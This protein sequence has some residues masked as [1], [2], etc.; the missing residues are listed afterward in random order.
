MTKDDVVKWDGFAIRRKVCVSETRD[1]FAC[2]GLQTLPTLRAA[3]KP[4]SRV[5]IGGEEIEQLMPD[6]FASG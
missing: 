5:R 1:T 2:D 4:W 3:H 6:L